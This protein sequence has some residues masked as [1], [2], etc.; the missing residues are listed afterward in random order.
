LRNC[1]LGADVE[2]I[3]TVRLQGRSWIQ[4]SASGRFSGQAGPGAAERSIQRLSGEPDRR[5][6][7]NESCIFCRLA[8]CV[9][10]RCWS[11]KILTHL[12]HRQHVV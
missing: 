7:P 10:R 12:I 3:H 5:V 4:F 9:S 11:V 6:R 1:H 8:L 2:T